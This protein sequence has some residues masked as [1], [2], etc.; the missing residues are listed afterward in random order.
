MKL[1]AGEGG[2]GRYFN[3][4]PPCWFSLSNSEAVKVG[5]LTFFSIQ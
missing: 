4:L 3:F 2:V 5:T 1:I